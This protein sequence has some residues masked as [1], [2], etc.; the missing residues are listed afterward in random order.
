[1]SEFQQYEF[2]AIDKPLNQEGLKAVGAMSSRVRLSPRKAVFTYNYSDF[3]QDEE[4]VLLGYFDFMLYMS[5]W[6]SKRIMMKFPLDMVDYDILKQYRISVVDCYSQDIRIVKKAGFLLLDINYVEEDSY[7]WIDEGDYGYNFLNMRDEIMNGNYQSL[8]VVWLKYLSMM[9]DGDSFSHSYSFDSGLIPDNLSTLGI[10]ASAVKDFFSIEE[11]WLDIM[12]SYSKKKEEKPFDIES[13]LL[14]MPKARMLEYMRMIVAGETNL[15]IRL[16][17]ELKSKDSRN[18]GVK[19]KQ[20]KLLEIGTKVNTAREARQKKKQEENARR[21]LAEMKAL[22][23]NIEECKTEI[24]NYIEKGGNKCYDAAVTN[25]MTLKRMHEFFNSRSEF[26]EFLNSLITK[27]SRKS[28]FVRRVR[29][30]RSFKD[31]LD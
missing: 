26:A 23:K 8:F 18:E 17:K 1:M 5:N 10:T 28:S 27:Y 3:R 31:Y 9:Y 19:S 24:I 13:K 16:I 30:N 2:H 15:T 22:R 20:I 25:L 11:D 12:I 4:K 29:L 7:D 6:G 21:E 14:E